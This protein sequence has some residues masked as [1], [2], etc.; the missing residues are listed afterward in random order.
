MAAAAAD[1]G[2]GGGA[3]VAGGRGVEVPGDR[4]PRGPG[5]SQV[6]G[7][8]AELL[9]VGG[10]RPSW[11]VCSARVCIPQWVGEHPV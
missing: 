3:L 11:R 6:L 2:G 8:D 1:F 4:V 10:W 9:V 5:S 7:C